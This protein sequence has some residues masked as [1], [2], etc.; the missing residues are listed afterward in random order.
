MAF[1]CLHGAP[2]QG[3]RTSGGYQWIHSGC[4]GEKGRRGFPV[5]VLRMGISGGQSGCKLLFPRVTWLSL[6]LRPTGKDEARG[7]LLGGASSKGFPGSPVVGF[8]LVPLQTG[9]FL[10]Q[11]RA[12]CSALEMGGQLIPVPCPAPCLGDL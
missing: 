5:C 4:V 10:A 6:G 7:L 3:E 8:G 9:W 2:F 11:H 12:L 1:P